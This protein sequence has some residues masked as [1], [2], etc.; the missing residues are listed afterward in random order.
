MIHK[1]TKVLETDRL[2]LR[3]FE[4]NDYIKALGLETK[5]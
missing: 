2:V 4:E 3:L 5:E 1:G